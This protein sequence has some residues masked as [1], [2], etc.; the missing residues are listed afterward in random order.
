VLKSIKIFIFISWRFSVIEFYSCGEFQHGRP[1][2]SKTNKTVACVCETYQNNRRITIREVAEGISY[3]IS[4][5]EILTKDI[6]MRQIATKCIPHL[7]TDEKYTKQ[8][9]LEWKLI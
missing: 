5:Q 2:T 8:N 3:G 1:L 4:Y 6:G 9:L 7:L